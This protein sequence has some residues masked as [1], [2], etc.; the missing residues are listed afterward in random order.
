MYDPVEKKFVRR[1]DVQFMEDQ[2]I[3]GIDKVKKSTPEKDNS[4]SKIDQVQMLVH[5]LDTT[6]NNVQNGEQHNY[7]NQQVGDDFDVPLDD[8]AEDEQEMSQDEN[9]GDAPEPH[10]VQLKRS[11]RYTSDEYV[12][13]TDEE[14]PECFQES[15]ESE[16][17]QKGKRL[18]NLN[19]RSSADM[20]TKIEERHTHRQRHIEIEIEKEWIFARQKREER[21]RE[22]EKEV[23]YYSPLSKA[24]DEI[25][26]SL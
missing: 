23:L 15:M 5:D 9:M 14:E 26:L 22:R 21:G 10:P 1:C 3:E 20:M 19:C 24:K 17:R 18:D 7:S 4:L 25:E 2:T 16:E 8:D 12:T 6:D 11:N 13:L